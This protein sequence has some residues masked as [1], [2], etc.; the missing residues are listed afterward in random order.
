MFCPNCGTQNTDQA[1]F[2]VSCGTPLKNPAE[3]NPTPIPTPPPTFNPNPLPNPG[4]QQ[5]GQQPAPQDKADTILTIVAFCFPIVGLILYFV[6]K[7]S[8]P[9]S[10]K[11]ICI[12]S[13]AGFGLGVLFYIIMAVIGNTASGY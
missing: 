3:T 10:A 1:A 12:A 6:W 9:N 7:D 4:Y 11:Q 13:V 5:F 8:R 2:C